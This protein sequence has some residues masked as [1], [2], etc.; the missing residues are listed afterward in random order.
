MAT[1]KIQRRLSNLN[2]SVIRLL[3]KAVE[4]NGA[5][6]LMPVFEGIVQTYANKRNG[7]MEQE[8]KKHRKGK[9]LT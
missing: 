8:L 2:K 1:E 6:D 5:A 9:S 3:T 4:G 7:I